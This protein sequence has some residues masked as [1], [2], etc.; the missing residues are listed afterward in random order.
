MMRWLEASTPGRQT[1]ASL[2]L[3]QSAH[4]RSSTI[5]QLTP[6]A[7]ARK[8]A[9]DRAS[10]GGASQRSNEQITASLSFGLLADPEYSYLC[11]LGPVRVRTVIEAL[12]RERVYCQIDR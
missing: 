11:H 4:G 3:S 9:P 6:A 5:I 8:P 7:R 12:S 10:L 2:A 1:E